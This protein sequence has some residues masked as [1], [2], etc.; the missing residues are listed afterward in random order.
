MW[1]W[2][3]EGSGTRSHCLP[4]VE[5]TT[6]TYSLLSY[7]KYYN[8]NSSF[9]SLS[10][11]FLLPPNPNMFMIMPPSEP[12]ESQVSISK[13]NPENPP[14]KKKTGITNHREDTSC[15]PARSAVH[16]CTSGFQERYQGPRECEN[17]TRTTLLR[18]C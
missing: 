8:H 17:H 1:S 2:E 11:S 16:I 7:G 3:I 15:P 4:T 5:T 12:N 18:L 10:P 14:T 9:P 13:Y 6:F